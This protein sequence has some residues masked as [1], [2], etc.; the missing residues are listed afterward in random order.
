MH[1]DALV[2]DCVDAF[3]QA[4]ASGDVDLKDFLPSSDHPAF[5]EVLVELIRV[6][7]ELAWRNGRRPKLSEYRDRFR[8]VLAV[9]EQFAPVAFEE[10]RLRRAAGEACSREEYRDAYS[11][12]TDG[13]HEL[14]TGQPCEN[15]SAQ[16]SWLRELSRTDPQSANRFAVASRQL[17]TVGQRFLGFDLIGELGRGA[18]GCVFLARQGDLANRFVALKVSPQIGDEPQRLAQLQHTNIVPIYSLHREDNLQAVCMPFLGPN[19]LADVLQ[20]FRANRLIPVSGHAL[21]STMAARQVSTVVREAIVERVTEQP[22][23]EETVSRSPGPLPT[24]KSQSAETLQRLDKMSYLDATA[25]LVGRIADGLAYAHEHGIVH[26]DLKPAN[27]LL[28]DDGEP[29]ILDFNLSSQSSA[30]GSSVA[31]VGG[32]L[33]YMAPEH[34]EALR[35]GSEVGPAADIYSLGVILFEMLTGQLP[36]PARRGSLDATISRML[37][38][39][40]AAAPNARTINGY[41]ST[42]LA[43]VVSKCLERDPGRRYE[44]A[45]QIHE[46]LHLHL[47]NRPLQYA[48]NRSLFERTHKWC[49]RHPR[50]VSSGSITAIASA[51]IVIFFSAWFIRGQRIERT[52]ARERAARLFDS[53]ADARMA[54]NVPGVDNFTLAEAIAAAEAAANAYDLAEV[55]ELGPQR[56]YQLLESSA[57]ADVRDHA[58]ELLYLLASG[59]VLQ[60]RRADSDDERRDLYHQALRYSAIAS[61]LSDN[62][63]TAALLLQRARVLDAMEKPGEA[64]QLRGRARSRMSATGHDRYLLAAEL[65]QQHDSQAAAE[66]LRKALRE[67]PQT[68]SYWFGLGST[69]FSLNRFSDAE[70][71]YTTCIALRPELHLAHYMRGVCRLQQQEYAEARDDFDTVLRLRPKYPAALVNRALACQGLG[72]HE[73]AV[74][75]LTRALEAGATQTRIYFIRAGLHAQLG[76]PKAAK[77]D[78]E[79]GLKR[80]PRDELSWIARGFAKLQDDPEGALSDYQ[81]A[82]RMNPNSAVALQNV[83]HVVSERLGRAEEA[84]EY[85]DRLVAQMPADANV[86]ASRGVLLARLGKRDAAV[87]DADAAIELAPQAMVLYRAACVFALLSS[88]EAPDLRARAVKLLGRVLNEQPRLVETAIRDADLL[89]LRND[90]VF[91]KL[92]SAA[93]MLQQA[94]AD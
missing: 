4:R 27:V 88:D 93:N 81:Q 75:D 77:K 62:R 50:L 49:R 73:K 22:A 45:R 86:L 69:L 91:L 90:P 5:A 78:R 84:V 17:P 55:K 80:T 89:A 8:D 87:T 53:V 65:L 72:R 16:S 64:S 57:Q 71:C 76:D 23:G 9:P 6:D 52:D 40:Q 1:D 15:G 61:G 74:D 58:S 54:L 11:I 66:L 24:G 82:L 42:D 14:P 30:V 20:T 39:R 38:D 32:T 59:K 26:R 21:V 36:Y 2:D 18:F 25:W 35:A 67:R 33:P 37:D 44:S 51:L 43:T 70:G 29:L 92:V 85:M 12:A 41:V 83:A 63:D 68:R 31:I 34:I 94:A 47:N 79:V 10:F 28:T 56:P 7:I 3:E 19:T 60:G 13:W 48:P 46:D